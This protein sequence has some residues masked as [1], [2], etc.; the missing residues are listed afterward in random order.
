MSD[1]V[2]KHFK[3]HQPLVRTLDQMIF[4]IIRYWCFLRHRRTCLLAAQFAGKR[5]DPATPVSEVDKFLW[6]KIFDHNPL[7]TVACD[8]LA[9]KEYALSVCPELKT[10]E[11]I[12]V[13]TDPDQIPPQ[14]L[15]GNVVIKANW[16]S[17]WN[18]F[19]RDGKVDREMVR[20]KA[21]SWLARPFGTERGEWGY[22]NARR[23]LFVEKM[24]LEGDQPIRQEY[25]LH[26]S[27]GRTAYAFVTR[28]NDN[29]ARAKCR[30]MRDGQFAPG[31]D[32]AAGTYGGIS[33]PPTF[34]RLVAIAERLALPF[35][36]MRCDL[37]EVGGAIFFSELTPYPQSG[38]GSTNRRCSELLN[39]RWDLRKSWFLTKSHRGWRKVYSVALRRWFDGNCLTHN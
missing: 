21:R 2:I 9:A 30:F 20:D 23:C 34:E 1:G 16:G 39:S 18:I 36:Y 22:K 35:D 28:R 14:V 15:S 32:E 26:V 19:V 13:G 37:Y 25:K 11:V 3:K 8:K 27:G 12:W 4:A 17:G 6:R 24:L 31:Q 10:A 7:F 33:L 5:P 38:R 29:D